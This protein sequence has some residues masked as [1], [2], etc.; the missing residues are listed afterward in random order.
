MGAMDKFLNIMKL[1]PDSGDDYYYDEEDV[2]DEEESTPAPAPVKSVP[3]PA[4]AAESRRETPARSSA[5]KRTTS[6]ARSTSA[7]AGHY[8]IC[9]ISPKSFEDAREIVETL[10][11]GK[12]VF[13]NLEGIDMNVAQRIIDFTSGSCFAIDGNLQKVSNYTFIITPSNVEISGDF[14]EKLSGHFAIPD[15]Y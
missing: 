7:S 8:G 13:L 6:P 5:P 14:Q 1:T 4:K 15:F 9:A 12:A 2:E 3:E 11:E 10:L